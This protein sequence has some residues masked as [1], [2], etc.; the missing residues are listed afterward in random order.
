[1]QRNTT[2]QK[3]TKTN[4]LDKLDQPYEDKK[5]NEDG[6]YYKFLPMT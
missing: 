1:M 4:L 6:E 3:R 5:L 2:N